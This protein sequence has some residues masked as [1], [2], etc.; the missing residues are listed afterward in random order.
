MMTR[1][2]YSQALQVLE[3]L[4]N[5]NESQAELLRAIQDDLTE[6]RAMSRQ[7]PGPVH[8]A[9]IQQPIVASLEADAWNQGLVPCKP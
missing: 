5:A 7:P 1:T 2:Q 3:R 6:L 8:F 4:A 9:T